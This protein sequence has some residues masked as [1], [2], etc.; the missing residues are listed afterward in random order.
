VVHPH[1]WSHRQQ[2]LLAIQNSGERNF[3][4]LQKAYRV[5]HARF[6]VGS[7]SKNFQRIL[8]HSAVDAYYDAMVPT[9]DQFQKISLPILTI[10]RQ[11]DGDEPGAMSYYPITIANASPESAPNIF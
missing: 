5:Q 10:T 7:P 4:M 6:V 9:A 3:S 1:Q 2:N 8:K 11:Y